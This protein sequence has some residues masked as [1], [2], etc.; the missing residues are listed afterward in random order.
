MTSGGGTKV[1]T[2]WPAGVILAALAINSLS[3]CVCGSLDGSDECSPLPG[4]L[5]GV[6]LV[7]AVLAV[8][9]TP[10]PLVAPPVAV[11]DLA[12]GR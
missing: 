10:N 3:I 8:H 5:E 4:L 6:L 2:P 7:G 1:S 12:E 11:A 9:A